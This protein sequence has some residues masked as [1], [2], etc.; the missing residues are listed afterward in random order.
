MLK[1]TEF[2]YPLP[3]E[4]IA[5]YPLEDRG[6]ARLLIVNRKTGTISHEVF[7]EIAGFFRKNDL[8]VLNDTKVLHCRLMGNK[9][10]G[11]RVEILLTR[12]I[13]GTTFSCLVQP[14]RTKVGE[15]IIFASGKVTGI[16]SSRGQIS[17]K[18]T[19]ADM[20]YNFGIVPLPPYIKR[21]P[22]D[23]DTVY[24]QTVYAKNEGALAAPTAGLH[25]TPESLK[26]IQAVGVNL[27]YVT[28]HVGLGT[29]RPVKCENITEHKMEPEYFLVPDATIAA[30]A[31]V[32]ADKGR[33]I[34]VGT[35]SLR[36]L[37][38]YASG[39]KEGNTDLFIYP[40]YKFASVDCLLTNFHLP[41]TTLF[42]LVCAFGGKDLMTKAY[43]EAVDKKY[44]FYSYGDAMLII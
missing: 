42:M 31:K 5:Q 26:Q 29:F 36:A 7:K 30:L 1:L 23:L 14:S 37:E 12:R 33:I 32:K 3:K 6:Q 19:D 44:R 4:L 27:G 8:L 25:F 28:L 43:Q 9:I 2:D 11:G 17:F 24:Y 10:T 16:L 41:M 15:K 13:N 18:Q 40:G 38:T 22:E 35:T 20:I 34:A 21:D 39:R